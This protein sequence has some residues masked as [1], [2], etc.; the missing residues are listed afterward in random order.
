MRNSLSSF[1][2]SMVPAL[3]SRDWEQSESFPSWLLLRP[4]PIFPIWPS[5]FRGRPPA[6]LP[7]AGYDSFPDRAQDILVV[8]SLS[9]LG[10]LVVF[11]SCCPLLSRPPSSRAKLGHSK[12]PSGDS[13]KSGPSLG[14]PLTVLYEGAQQGEVDLRSRALGN[15]V[16]HRFKTRCLSRMIAP[17]V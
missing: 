12:W 6:L 1:C 9:V 11:K 7:D 10:K 5:Q 4:G 16:S 2:L 17:K 3:L 15:R 8:R 14:P 13:D